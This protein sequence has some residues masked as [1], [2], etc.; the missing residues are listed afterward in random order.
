MLRQAWRTPDGFHQPVAAAARHP[1]EAKRALSEVRCQGNGSLRACRAPARLFR[2]NYGDPSAIKFRKGEGLIEEG[3]M[4]RD[5]VMR[6][7]RQCLGFREPL[8]SASVPMRWT[9]ALRKPWY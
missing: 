9:P 7:A 8:R 4:E 1:P 2:P 5:F 6:V 3:M